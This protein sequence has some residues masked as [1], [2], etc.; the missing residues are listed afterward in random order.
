[1][2]ER[3]GYTYRVDSMQRDISEKRKKAMTIA[4]VRIWIR[5][6]ISL[7]RKTDFW[8]QALSEPIK[9]RVIIEGLLWKI[10]I[11]TTISVVGGK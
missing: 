8:I 7:V 10:T 5:F 1:M 9:K 4:N 11:E 2:K 3:E 6:N